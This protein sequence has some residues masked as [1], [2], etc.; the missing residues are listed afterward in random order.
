MAN[1]FDGRKWYLDTVVSTTSVTTD[2]IVVSKI[3]WVSANA[4]GHLARIS[5]ANGQ[6]VNG[7]WTS[8]A[9]GAAYVEESSFLS[10]MSR[11]KRT[12]NGLRVMSL[13][14]GVIELYVE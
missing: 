14:S 3:R 9:S 4:L 12:L 8:V 5:D 13:T 10:D 2:Q 6:P 7:F 11:D 1:S